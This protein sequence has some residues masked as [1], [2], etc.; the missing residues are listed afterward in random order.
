VATLHT[1]Y[2]NSLC[3]Q[4]AVYKTLLVSVCWFSL[5]LR[6]LDSLLLCKEIASFVVSSRMG[7]LP[8]LYRS[9]YQDETFLP[10]K[11][12]M[13]AFFFSPYISRYR[14][15]VVLYF[16]RALLR[17]EGNISLSAYTAWNNLCILSPA[18]MST[19]VGL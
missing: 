3:V 19:P 9:G 12:H 11:I 1:V 8:S 10:L 6:I 14:K 15:V 4:N 17:A 13:H 5:S 2:N 7:R 16:A 18:V